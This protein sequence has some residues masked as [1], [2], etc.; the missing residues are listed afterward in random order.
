MRWMVFVASALLIGCPESV[1]GPVGAESGTVAVEPDDGF[2]VWVEPGVLA[3][4]P[5]PEKAPGGVATWVSGLEQTAKGP[6]AILNL[7]GAVDPDFGSAVVAVK[8]IPIPDFQIPTAEQVEAAL[9][10]IGGQRHAGRT[11]VVHCQGG[12]GRTGTI[13]ALYLRQERGISGEEA[14]AELRALNPCFVETAQQEEMVLTFMFG[15]PAQ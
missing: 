4:S 2:V 9:A 3:A 10:F 8:Q 13:L 14:L 5:A 15:T 11:V 12:C 1:P 6:L 7:R